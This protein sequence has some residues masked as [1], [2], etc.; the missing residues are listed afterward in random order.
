M[1]ALLLGLELSVYASSKWK[2][3]NV[4]QKDT[5]DRRVEGKR[6]TGKR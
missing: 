2:E 6:G 1:S 4:G 5:E 3:E